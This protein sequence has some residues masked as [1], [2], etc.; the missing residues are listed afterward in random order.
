MAFTISE[1]HTSARNVLS[2]HLKKA[3][4]LA[5]LSQGIA[6]G[7]NLLLCV[8]DVILEATMDQNGGLSGMALRS[9]LT[10]VTSIFSLAV[11]FLTPFWNINLVFIF[12]GFARN[13]DQSTGALLEGFHRFGPFLR[14]ILLVFL[15]TS[16]LSIGI[17]YVFSILVSI[18]PTNP[19]LSAIILENQEAFFTDPEATIAL[20]PRHLL[21]EA[22]L[23]AIGILFLLF[24]LIMIPLSY[25]LRLGEYAIMDKPGTTARAA[26]SFSLRRM[27]GNCLKAFRLDLHF[28]WYYLALAGLSAL[29][30]LDSLLSAIGIAFPFS[31]SASR[32][33][34]YALYALGMLVLTWYAIPIVQTTYA[35]FY[36]EINE[37]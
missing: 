23:P 5:L 18:L 11:N 20:I 30:Q 25:R 9:A 14:Y 34:C 33:I 15:L 19:E 26:L 1:L 3:Q 16:G 4:K 35:K 32:L 28:W 37:E 27:R 31:G 36:T 2:P 17:F 12:L 13:Q 8:L 21:L 6:L 7:V 22:M 29:A 24:L 10:T